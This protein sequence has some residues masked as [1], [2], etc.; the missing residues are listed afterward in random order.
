MDISNQHY[1]QDN[2]ARRKFS[3]PRPIS[4]SKNQRLNLFDNDSPKITSLD[5]VT[6]SANTSSKPT[7]ITSKPLS[8][9]SLDH[10]NSDTKVN[11]IETLISRDRK[12][13]IEDVLDVDQSQR[14]RAASRR[15]NSLEKDPKHYSVDSS[16]IAGKGKKSGLGGRLVR[17]MF[18]MIVSL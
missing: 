15:Q 9:T 8:S 6:S 11:E 17:K 2:N 7:V 18:Q 5:S 1:F 16:S 4:A 14:P 13:S 10:K 3:K 12:K